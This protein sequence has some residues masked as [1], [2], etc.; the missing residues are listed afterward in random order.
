MRMERSVSVVILIWHGVLKRRSVTI[1]PRESLVKE[2]ASNKGF[3]IPAGPAPRDVTARR[4]GYASQST[5]PAGEYVP[6]I[7]TA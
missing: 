3:I 6:R 4:R 1:R 2:P 5:F 7:L